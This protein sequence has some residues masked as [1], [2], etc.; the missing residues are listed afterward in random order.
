MRPDYQ[1]LADD[2]DVTSSFRDQLVS[3]SIS[4]K[5]GVESDECEIVV[6]DH[7]GLIALP[8]RGVLVRVRIGWKGAGLIDKGAYEVDEVEHSGP[9]DQ[10][11][12]KGRAAQLKGQIKNQRDLSY[13]DQSLGE[14]LK[15]VAGRH[16]LKPAIDPTFAG[17]KIGHID[18]T[19]ESDL[20]FLTRL[21]KDY[22][23]IAT[24][25][26]GHLLF[27]PAGTG[28]SASGQPLPALTITRTSTTNHSFTISDR[29]G[30]DSGVQAQYR[31]LAS[32]E[33]KK[34]TAGAEDGSVKTLKPVYPTEGE[35]KAAAVAAVTT[36]KRKQREIRI[37]MDRG[38][39]EMIAGQPLKLQGWRPE[40][41]DVAWVVEELT[42][43]LTGDDGLHT[44][45]TAHGV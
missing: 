20:N 1:I 5:Q 29:E 16:G 45:F 28:R 25:K 18:Q 8:R 9:P 3:L 26:D 31:D 27:A 14:I 40:I 19:N 34:V 37:T 22:G 41:D 13:H 43:T 38:R 11:R 35:A 7:R 24:V 44:S 6:S 21:G 23:A 15:A 32:A 39:P 30:G 36:A 12:I 2:Q 42:H 33:T 17:L 10:V 4:D